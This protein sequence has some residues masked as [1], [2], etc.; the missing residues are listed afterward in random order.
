M[1]LRSLLPLCTAAVFAA[2]G[3]AQAGD[4][5]NRLMRDL[6]TV[7]QQRDTLIEQAAQANRERDALK[8]QLDAAQAEIAALRQKVADSA[9][10]VA[11]D[12][13]SAQALKEAQMKADMT[14]R[15]F[16]IKDEEAQRAQQA[17]TLAA[18]K[19]AA[20]EHERDTAV[21]DAR[22]AAAECDAAKKTEA[23]A[24]TARAQMQNELFA[25]QI[26]IDNLVRAVAAQGGNVTLPPAPTGPTPV[27]VEASAPAAAPAEAAKAAPAADTAPRTHKVAEGE[28]LSLLAFKYYGSPN[29]WDKIFAANRDKLKNPDQVHPGMV[30]KIP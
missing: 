19:Q 29:K 6:R 24:L 1:K 10:Q 3:F 27:A 17:A 15:A 16:A 11:T 5:A 9:S 30:L 8:T 7:M 22:R 4:D 13:A 2:T 26:R 14:V 21:A 20:A 18:Q 12:S 23:A 28:T 25:A